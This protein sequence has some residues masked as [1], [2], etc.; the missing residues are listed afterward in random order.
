VSGDDKE[1]LQKMA[2]LAKHTFEASFGE[3]LD[4]MP[5]ILLSTPFESAV[6]TMVEWSSQLL[7]REAERRSFGTIEE[8]RSWLKELVSETDSPSSNERTRGPWPFIRKVRVYLKAYILSKGLIIADLPGLRDLNSARQAITERY[9]RQCHQVLV[10]AKIDRAI[11]DESI[12]QI[13]DLATKVDQTKVDIVC[14]R[15]EDVQLKQA[16]D[17]WPAERATIKEM[18]RSIA[19]EEQEVASLKREIDKLGEDF[20]NL[21]LEKA[22]RLLNLQ[23]KMKRTEIAEA[24][25][26]LKL[27]HFIVSLRNDKVK[28]GLQEEYRNHPL[29]TSLRIFCVSNKVYWNNREK[30]HDVAMPYLTLSGILDLRRHCIGVVAQSRLRAIRILIKDEI[31]AF[32]GS[33][34][35]W[36]E[37]GFGDPSTESKKQ[38]LDAV[39]TMQQ[40]LDEVRN[41]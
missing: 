5:E 2:T 4:D 38:I 40:E 9:F 20:E 34:S 31:P 32:I 22:Q 39:S 25:Q 21:T 33:I 11:T 7:P 13:F 24:E 26:V 37:A 16:D 27:T 28:L 6:T 23:K 36:V 35:L 18:Q 8:C 3:R 30:P 1:I 12:K 14:T 15:S 10:V 29:A 19:A 41:S 17:D